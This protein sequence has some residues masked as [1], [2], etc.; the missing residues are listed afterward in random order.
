MDF[1][2]EYK[3]KNLNK[4]ACTVCAAV[5]IAGANFPAEGTVSEVEYK[6][7][8]IFD[9]CLNKK[10]RISDGGSDANDLREMK[11]EMLNC[12]RLNL[13]LLSDIGL[14]FEEI[15]AKRGGIVHAFTEGGGITF[16]FECGLGDYHWV[17][18]DIDYVVDD[19]GYWIMELIHPKYDA[20]CKMITWIRPKNLF[21]GLTYP[22]NVSDIEEIYDVKC[23]NTTFLNNY[24]GWD[25]G[26]LLL[27]RDM[28]VSILT[29]EEDIVE[30]NSRVDVRFQKD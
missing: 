25:Y 4:T 16:R 29:S 3:M 23:I 17:L 12:P 10:D 18:E 15:K 22:I 14:T 24:D 30:Q 13:D 20:V 28:Y 9:L 26:S 21:L 7:N 27:Y 5:L 6:G 8:S 2:E 11:K 1:M 19:N